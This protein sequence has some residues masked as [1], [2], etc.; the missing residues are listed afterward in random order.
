MK[1]QPACWVTLRV[2]EGQRVKN[3]SLLFH[4]LDAV[5]TSLIAG[6][7]AHKNV[8]NISGHVKQ[9]LWWYW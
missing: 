4:R 9:M 8:H 5:I 2:K 1:S 3:R 7:T 6:K